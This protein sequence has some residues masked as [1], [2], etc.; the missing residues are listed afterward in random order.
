MSILIGPLGFSGQAISGAERA[1]RRDALG[2]DDI[3][4]SIWQ[5]ISM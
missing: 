3:M 4:E 1:G 2:T 5:L